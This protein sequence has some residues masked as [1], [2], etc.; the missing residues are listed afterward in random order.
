MTKNSDYIQKHRDKAK[1]GG[2]VRK[3]AYIHSSQVE[4]FKALTAKMA[5]L[6]FA[7]R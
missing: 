4:R 1:E 3:E 2:L 6:E 5:Y 7:E